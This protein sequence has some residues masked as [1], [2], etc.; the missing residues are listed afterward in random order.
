[1]KTIPKAKI[2][3]ADVSEKY[4]IALGKFLESNGFP[5]LCS[6]CDEKSLF[7]VLRKHNPDI[8][9]YDLFLSD[10]R[11]SFERNMKEILSINP[12]IK[13]L[14]LSIDEYE[15][16]PELCMASGALGYC[17]KTLDINLILE[18]VKKIDKSEPVFLGSETL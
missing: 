12:K 17:L 6:V 15:E 18:L 3:I 2:V 5:V 7:E 4:G 8:L 10:G 13:T 9:I 14:V 1:M 11:F 16:V